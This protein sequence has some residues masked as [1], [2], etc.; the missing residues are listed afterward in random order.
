MSVDEVPVHSGGAP[1][2]EVRRL[3]VSYETRPVLWDVDASFPTGALS[4]IVGPN[5][6]GKSTLLR[7]ALGLIPAD[8][9]QALVQG[10]PAR[11][12]LDRVAFVPQR[13]AVDWD[14]PIT[15][16]E[17][18]EMGRYPVRGWLRRLTGED[19]AIVDEALE[20]VGMGPFARRQIGRL[21]G[22]Q[23]QRVFIARALARQ[24]PVMLLD[25]PFAGIDARTEATLLDLLRELR[26]EG[27]SI[28]VVHHDLGT[29][30]ASF[31]WALVLNVR[32]VA[33]GPVGE[34]I[35][36]QTLRRAYGTDAVNDGAQDG[37][38]RWVR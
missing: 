11:S 37:E 12:A 26:A 17:V 28:V 36:P 30:R 38:L 18:V 33:C 19:R 23:R 27:R 8:A 10:R 29:V 24:A 14:F 13:D 31:D 4:A 16:R 22:G 35:V 5:G 20:R 1:A 6:A 3:T 21:S 7:A 2:L 32:A 25:E 34:V 15:V 9:G